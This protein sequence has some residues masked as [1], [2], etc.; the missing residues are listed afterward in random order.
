MSDFLTRE[1][2]LAKKRDLK[3]EMVSVPEWG[4]HVWVRELTGAERNEFELAAS[5][6]KESGVGVL[7]CGETGY[8]AKFCACCIVDE[9][10]DRLFTAD[11]VTD[12]SSLGAGALN[13]CFEMC[14]KLS[15][16]TG[17]DLDTITGNSESG[18]S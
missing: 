11:D 10:G 8:L 18:Q 17:D 16:L 12:V 6:S 5:R 15:G 14:L 2:I 13:R 7:D 1:E 4:G 3:R 9:R